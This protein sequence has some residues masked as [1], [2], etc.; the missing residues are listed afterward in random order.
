MVVIEVMRMGRR[1]SRPASRMEG[2]DAQIPDFAP[3]PGRFLGPLP[4]A[5]E[6]QNYYRRFSNCWLRRLFGRFPGREEDSPRRKQIQ[7]A[8]IGST[9]HPVREN[10]GT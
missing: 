2:D 10:T 1:R 7:G 9:A 6:E 5:P 4:L 3:G 8:R